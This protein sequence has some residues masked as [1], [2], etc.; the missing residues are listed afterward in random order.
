MY[1]GECGHET[2][3]VEAVEITQAVYDAARCG[4]AHLADAEFVRG[5]FEAAGIR[6]QPQRAELEEVARLRDAA[7]NLVRQ[8]DCL[9]SLITPE[10]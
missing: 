7:A 8:A 3:A 2:D 9:Q 5:I 1:C 4:R 6:V 10:S